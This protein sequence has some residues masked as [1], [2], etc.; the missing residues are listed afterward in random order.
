MN[1]LIVT[2]NW[3]GDVLFQLPAIQAIRNQYP[4]AEITCMTPERCLDVLRAH[5]AVD[6][7][8]SFDERTTHRSLVSK[9]RMIAMLRKTKWDKAYLFHRSN[10][11][12]LLLALGGIRQRVGFGAR[13]RFFLTRAYPEP[14]RQGHHADTMLELLRSEGFRVPERGE[15]RFYYSQQDKIRALQLMKHSG[16]KENSFVVFHLGANWEPKR[17][18][19][20]HYAVL[21]DWI[22]ETLGLPVAVTGAVTDK[23]LWELFRKR[24]TKARVVSLMGQTSLAETGA[25]FRN[26]AFLVTGDSGPMH[27][28]SGV[29]TSVVALFG[30]TH[31]DISGPRG[32]GSREVLSFVPEGCRAPWFKEIPADGWM[33]HIRPESVQQRILEK[34][35]GR[36]MIHAGSEPVSGRYLLTPEESRVRRILWVTLSNFGDVIMT[37]P[38]LRAL[39]G[40]FPNAEITAVVS[41]RALSVL[42]K[43]RMIKRFVIYDKKLGLLN[44]WS[45]LRELRQE[46]Y[47]VVVDLRNSAMPWL[48]RAKQ[49]SPFWRPFQSLSMRERHLEILSLMKI[50]AVS[51]P[52]FDFFQTDDEKTAYEKL[53]A[54]GVSEQNDFILCAPVAASGLKT[55][56]IEKFEQTLKQIL[57]YTRSSILIVGDS[58]ERGMAQRLESLGA[59]RVFN[60][61]G[62]TTFPETAALVARA[63]LVVANDS[64]LMHLAFEMGT[65]AAAVFGPTHHEKY[66]HKGENF[67]VVRAGSS[68]SPCEQPRCRFSRQ[69][70]FE[71]LQP[72]ALAAACKELL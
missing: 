19:P 53:K 62:E 13:N 18:P 17:W 5:P 28:A 35:L 21:A 68:C 44:Q 23:P 25:I 26:A 47:D 58:R 15:Y 37:T 24:V 63:R 10:S 50:R 9:V 12:A 46:Q 27:V 67:K 1:I 30:P 8:I 31:P 59:G 33:S 38:V 45:F 52:E 3:I 42:E 6:H 2:K 16:L 32:S 51:F 29:G 54:R 65:P 55:W 69:H 66:G 49:R 48:V 64:A 39:A 60:F 40:K 43:S 14:A 36:Q 41:P 11:R 70:C 56:P 61:C 34:G 72:Q 57:E 22:H 4:Q 71:D 7:L 20:E